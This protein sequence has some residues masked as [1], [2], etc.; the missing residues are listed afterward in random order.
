MSAPTSYKQSV[1]VAL[2]SDGDIRAV[3]GKDYNPDTTLNV[4]KMFAGTGEMYPALIGMVRT[5]F[6]T[7]DI[8]DKH[9]EMIILRAASI[10]DVPYEWQANNVMASNAGLTDTE[11]QATT[12]SGPVSG[13]APEY[14]LICNATDE[15]LRGGTLT[16]DTLSSMLDTFGPV[17]TRKYAVTIAW[18][19]M[20]SLFLNAT[21]TP[22]ETTDKIGSRTSPLG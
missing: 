21:R 19:S 4:I 6:G 20:L 9:R 12:S 14:V 22:L 17:V 1:A 18:F 16:D 7:P 3:M 13:I 5:I 11:I 2:P 10:L 8:N 15:L